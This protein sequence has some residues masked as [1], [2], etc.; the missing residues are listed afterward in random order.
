MGLVI[1]L[2]KRGIYSINK[3]RIKRKIKAGSGVNATVAFKRSG[4][5]GLAIFRDVTTA[6]PVVIKAALLLGFAAFLYAVIYGV[7]DIRYGL[8]PWDEPFWTEYTIWTCGFFAA[9]GLLDRN[10]KE[11]NAERA[12]EANSMIESIYHFIRSRTTENEGRRILH[13]ICAVLES[14]RISQ[15][16]ISKLLNFSSELEAGQDRRGKLLISAYL[17]LFSDE[18]GMSVW[19]SLPAHDKKCHADLYR[20]RYG[21][22]IDTESME[23]QDG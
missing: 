11:I 8:A 20:L 22:R 17:H 13:S 10:L 3:Y 18:V 4:D 1:Y 14:R 15:E 21:E 23:T 5:R 16:K 19:H 12:E 2:V 6:L 9:A 7:T